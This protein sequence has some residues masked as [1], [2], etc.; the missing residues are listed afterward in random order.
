VVGSS[1]SFRMKYCVHYPDKRCF[2]SSCSFID[3]MGNV[4][5]CFLHPNGNGFFK[6]RVVVPSLCSP[7]SKHRHRGGV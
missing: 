4:R 3:S 6:R 5:V 2:H 1:G 7:F